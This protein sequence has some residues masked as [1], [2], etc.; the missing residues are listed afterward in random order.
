MVVGIVFVNSIAFVLA[1]QTATSIG[2]HF[3]KGSTKAGAKAIQAL[4]L[5]VV[6]ICVA[7]LTDVLT[8]EL[9]KK[10]AVKENYPWTY[11]GI[12][13]GTE[14]AMY[15]AQYIFN[16]AYATIRAAI[17]L[18]TFIIGR[19]FAVGMHFFTTIM[20]KSIVD[21]PDDAMTRDEK[22]N[23]G[24]FVGVVIHAVW[25]SLASVI[26]VLQSID[27]LSRE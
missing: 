20:Q 24:Y 14:F 27:I 23:L 26:P 15:I 17:S 18:G 6:A 12:F 5:S 9:G 25:N 2:Y 13:A 8:E 7:P 1:Q 11:T 10:I 22:S 16:P 4:V 19:L 21:N 3:G